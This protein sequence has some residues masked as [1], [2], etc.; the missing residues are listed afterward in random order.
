[1][2]VLVCAYCSACAALCDSGTDRITANTNQPN[3][4][5]DNKLHVFYY[6]YCYIIIKNEKIRVTLCENDAATLYTVNR[7]CVNGQRNVQW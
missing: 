1:V 7:M 6:Y 2:L 4:V 5:A 3:T